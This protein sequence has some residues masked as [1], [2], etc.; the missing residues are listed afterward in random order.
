MTINT[1]DFVFLRQGKIIQEF[2]TE[3][4]PMLAPIDVRG[5]EKTHALML[6][7]GFGAT[8]AVYRAMLPTLS[9]QYDAVVGPIFPGHCENLEAFAKANDKVWY[10][11]AEQT[12]LALT[13][14]YQHVDVMGLS[15]GGLIACQ[16]SQ[17]YTIHHLYLLAP[18]LSLKIFAVKPLL[19]LAKI[20]R[21]LNIKSL[22]NQGANLHASQYAE[23]LYKKLPLSAIIAIFKRID[24]Y[25]WWRPTCP[26][27]LFLGYFDEVVDSP[28][29]A[30]KF[31][32]KPN[33]N[34]HW[35]MNSAHILPLDGDI[36]GILDVVSQ[37][38]L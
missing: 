37:H 34:I 1:E 38:T 8:P 19:I 12:Y 24:G 23:L 4:K 36:D 13:K 17:K 27:D 26:T 32:K 18:A 11:T 28:K 10:E 21:A 15:L 20:M 6:L 33:I 30:K 31:A 16:L 14:E 3:D 25:S 9:T 22:T 29:I 35:L 2:G 7:H 5:P